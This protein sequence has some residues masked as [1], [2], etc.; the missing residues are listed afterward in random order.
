M[1]KCTLQ[2]Y[3]IREK[4]YHNQPLIKEYYGDWSLVWEWFNEDHAYLECPLGMSF[5]VRLEGCPHFLVLHVKENQCSK[6]CFSHK[7]DSYSTR[8]V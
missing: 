7:I 8:L 4:R 5:Q 6:K 1:E 3:E 2:V